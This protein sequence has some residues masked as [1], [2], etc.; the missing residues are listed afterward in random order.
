[1]CVSYYRTGT[2]LLTEAREVIFNRLSVNSS[3]LKARDVEISLT[4]QAVR[5]F[6][7]ID[8]IRLG[9][10]VGRIKIFSF[11]KQI[12]ISINSIQYSSGYIQTK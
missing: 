2:A 1:M 9:P 12:S 6:P 5:L 4:A 10:S 3:H 8:Q 11:S 7:W